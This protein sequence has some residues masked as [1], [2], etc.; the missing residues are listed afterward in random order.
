VDEADQMTAKAQ[1]Q[2]LSR[3]DGTAALKPIYGGGLERGDPPPIIWIFT[4]NGRGPFE[5]QPPSGL[6]KRFLSRCMV[7]AFTAPTDAELVAYLEHIW[8]LETGSR[9]PKPDFAAMARAACNNVRDA[10]MKLDLAVM[11]GVEEPS[12][13]PLAENKPAEK[14]VPGIKS[15]LIIDM[16]ASLTAALGQRQAETMLQLAVRD[17]GK[18]LFVD[19]KIGRVTIAVANGIPERQLLEALR[20]R[21]EPKGA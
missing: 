6:A 15:R 3:L 11:G 1:L 16:V 9:T 12:P 2:L 21:A 5:T 8:N 13:A 18:R 17:C 19:G 20:R 10:L 4:C 7:M 14:A